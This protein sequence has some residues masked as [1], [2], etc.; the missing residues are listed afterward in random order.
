MS[1]GI[2][3]GN[4]TCQ[5]KKVETSVVTSTDVAQS[6]TTGRVDRQGEVRE[7]IGHVRQVSGLS[8]SRPVHCAMKKLLLRVEGGSVGTDV[9]MLVQM[10][11]ISAG[12]HA[13]EGA[14]IWFPPSRQL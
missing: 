11:E 2:D 7:E 12:R 4:V 8:C 14:R 5:E 13:L 3:R 6:A 9:Q 10:G 1:E